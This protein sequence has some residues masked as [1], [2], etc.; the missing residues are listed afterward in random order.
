MHMN[1]HLLPEGTTHTLKRRLDPQTAA[2]RLTKASEKSAVHTSKAYKVMLNIWCCWMMQQNENQMTLKLL[3]IEYHFSYHILLGA[4]L[5]LP[6]C[7]EEELLMIAYNLIYR[8]T[9]LLVH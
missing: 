9:R 5:R 7:P 6:Q 1:K 2:H 8:V 3:T 4:A